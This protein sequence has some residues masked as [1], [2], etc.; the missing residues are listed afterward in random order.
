MLF[1]KPI[2]SSGAA[3]LLAACAAAPAP[4]Y[5]T[6]HPANPAAAPAP[7][8]EALPSALSTYRDAPA[9]PAPGGNTKE[10]PHA[11]HH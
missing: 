7:A 4:E 3:L 9:A 2:M 8:P 10:D 11:N 5:A 6:D 1:A